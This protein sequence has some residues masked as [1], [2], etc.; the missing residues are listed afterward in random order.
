MA[1][2]S[3]PRRGPL[4]TVGGKLI[5]GGEK[6]RKGPGVTLDRW[7][8]LVGETEEGSGKKTGELVEGVRREMEDSGGG[9][10]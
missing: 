2:T 3:S 6:G 4:I 7:L 1:R 5:K 8:G 10:E 9:R